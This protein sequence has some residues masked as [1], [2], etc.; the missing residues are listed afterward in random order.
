M[1]RKMKKKKR[2]ESK[3]IRCMHKRKIIMKKKMRTINL[4][5]NMN[6]NKKVRRKIFLK[7]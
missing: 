6:S 2:K 5:K 7:T 1:N 3:K 4:L